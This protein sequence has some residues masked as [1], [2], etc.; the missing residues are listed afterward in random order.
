MSFMPKVDKEEELAE[1]K[2]GY[3]RV[4]RVEPTQAPAPA[5]A[6]APAAMDTV[7]Q[8][9]EKEPVA[10]VA[11]KQPVTKPVQV[12]VVKPVVAPTPP[13]PTQQTVAVQSALSN[14]LNRALPKNLPVSDRGRKVMEASIVPVASGGSAGLKQDIGAQTAAGAV[15]TSALASALKSGTGGAAAGLKGFKGGAGEGLTQGFGNG[16]PSMDVGMGDSDAETSGGLDKSVIAAIV[17][18]HL[19]QIK[20]CYERQLLV[21]PSIFGKVV[22]NWT[23]NGE[24][25]VDA[26]SVKKTTLGNVNVENCVMGKIKG[27]KFPKPRGGGK[28]IVSY[29]FLFKSVN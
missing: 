1:K 11:A 21:D 4:T 29:P 23:I 2:S 24:G 20:H 5:P 14:L 8:V 10:K 9:V 27:W 17:R 19:G 25:I 26:T 15:N 7:D 22:A 18:E 12:A 28:V 13:K 3:Y 16:P 6:P